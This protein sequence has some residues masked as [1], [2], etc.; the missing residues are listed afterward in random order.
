MKIRNT[1]IFLLI[2]VFA[3]CIGISA[4][5]LEEEP[6]TANLIKIDGVK[7]TSNIP[8]FEDYIPISSW[9]VGATQNEG[10]ADYQDFNFVTTQGAYSAEFFRAM[11]TGRTI[12]SVIFAIVNPD[13][14]KT[15]KNAVDFR[16]T[17]KNVK[18]TSYQLGGSEGNYGVFE[19]VSLTYQSGTYEG[20]NFDKN[21]KSLPGNSVDFVVPK[22]EEEK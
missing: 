1:I 15:G 21:Q 4:Q 2:F 13:F 14:S 19:Q 7:G 12:P 6:A 18:F 20:S 8:G 22:K 10:K 16:F 9:S 3:G 5:N 11:A 17:M